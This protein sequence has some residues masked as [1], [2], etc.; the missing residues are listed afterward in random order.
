MSPNKPQVVPPVGNRQINIPSGPVLIG[1]IVLILAFWLVRGGPAY[2]IEPDEEGIVLRFGKYNRSTQPGFH[3]KAPWP[4]ETVEKPQVTLTRR[5]EFGFRTEGTG[6]NLVY[7]SFMDDHAY[8]IKE[9]QMLT[10]DENVVNCSMAIQYKISDARMYLFNYATAEDVEKALQDIGEAALRQ[11]VGD[12]PIDDVLTTGKDVVQDE[13]EQKVQELAKLYEMGIRV[14]ALQLQDVQPPEEVKKAFTDVASAREERAQIINEAK[15]YQS[16]EIPLAEGKA[17]A[18]KLEASAYKEARIAQAEGAVS[19][20]QAIELQYREAPE[21]TRTQLY[22]DAMEQLLP[23][24][25]ITVVDDEAGLVNFKSLGGGGASPLEPATARPAP[26]VR[27]AQV[28]D[29]A[30]QRNIDGGTRRE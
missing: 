8:L 12:H 19:R 4:I 6:D 18:L 28:R 17:E 23:L 2:R 1:L 13:V 24:L 16:R 29:S 11:A 14:T 30:G 26:V 15:A 3:F 5:I 20:F 21:L 27:P 10:G 7:R 9:A 25:K 22:L